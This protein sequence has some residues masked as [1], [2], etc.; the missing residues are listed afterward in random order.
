LRRY[1]FFA[2]FDVKKRGFACNCPGT[3]WPE[4]P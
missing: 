3:H 1:R 4:D 2:F